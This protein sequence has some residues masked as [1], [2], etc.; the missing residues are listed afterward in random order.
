MG[1]SDERRRHPRI[2]LDGRMGGR[3]TVLADFRVAA[4]SEEGASLEM[5]LPLVLGSGCD[6]IL[7]LSHVAVDIQARVTEVHPPTGG[8]GPYVVDVD[9]VSVDELDLGLLQ[10]FIERE[11]R[12]EP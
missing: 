10:S 7:N 6:L 9:F 5:S 8:G 1:D 3:A 12:R 2:R 11:R 4:L